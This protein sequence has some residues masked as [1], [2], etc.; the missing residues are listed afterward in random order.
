MAAKR[1]FI[2]FDYDHDAKHRDYVV[3]QAKNPRSPFNITDWSLKKRIPGDWKREMRERIRLTDLVIVL[4]GEY[5]HTATGVAAEVKIAREEGKPYFL[6]KARRNK[7][8][9]KPSTA[10]R[11]DE[12]LEWTWDNLRKQIEGSTLIE[13]TME[14]LRIPSPWVLTGVAGLILLLLTSQSRS[15]GSRVKG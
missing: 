8:C 3:K 2:S 5:T 12:I 11:R 14:W 4:C 10:L 1:V 13:S 7:T 15:Q 6:L 9:T